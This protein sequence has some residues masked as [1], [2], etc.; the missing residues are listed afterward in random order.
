MLFQIEYIVL[1]SLVEWQREKLGYRVRDQA[2]IRIQ[3]VTVNS[4]INQH[5]SRLCRDRF[6]WLLFQID[7]FLLG[8]LVE[9]QREKLGYRVRDQVFIR[10]Q[11]ATVNS[12]FQ[13]DYFLLGSLVE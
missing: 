8:S 13:I 9:W 12:I 6:C 5:V 10:I 7:Y 1:G 11:D 3:D 4:T 2:F